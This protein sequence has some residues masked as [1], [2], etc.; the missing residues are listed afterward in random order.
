MNAP[1]PAVDPLHWDP[2]ARD[3]P[4]VSSNRSQ[5]EFETAVRT[6]KAIS[7]REMFSS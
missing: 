5:A 2:N 4:D 6:A 3:L 7:L 1:L